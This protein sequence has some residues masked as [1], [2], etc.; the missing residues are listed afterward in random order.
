MTLLRSL[1]PLTLIALLSACGGGGGGGGASGG[2]GGGS[3]GGGG[4]GGGAPVDPV[5]PVNPV[6]GGGPSYLGFDSSSST[7]VAVRL[8][9]VD[10]SGSTPTLRNAEGRRQGNTDG[11]SI[12][13]LLDDADGRSSTDIW[14][15]GTTRIIA[16]EDLTTDP[17]VG[18]NGTYAIPVSVNENNSQGGAVRNYSV[19]GVET[20]SG[21][22]PSSGTASFEGRAT[23]GQILSGGFADVRGDARLDASFAGAGDVDVTVDNLPSGLAYDEVR[24]RNMTISGATFEGGTVTYRSGGSTVTPEGS[25]GS[26]ATVGAFYG[27]DGSAPLE[28][29]GAWVTTGANGQIFGTF[30]TDDRTSP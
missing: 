14:A 18:V 27:A 24:L 15:D 26:D 22:M 4:S 17:F 28:A 3:T 19:V 23:V 13:G 9:G 12:D 2:G 5:D 10:R 8:V 11:L 16:T 1:A 25:G 21:D 7:V 20:R 6:T 29:G 30:L